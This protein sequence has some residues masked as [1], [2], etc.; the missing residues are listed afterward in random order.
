MPRVEQMG[1][2]APKMLADFISGAEFLNEFEV[3]ISFK[4][5]TGARGMEAKSE[6]MNF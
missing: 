3:Q 1:I 5:R 2:I 4:D 6:D